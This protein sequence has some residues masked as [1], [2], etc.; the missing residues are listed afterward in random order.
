M[1]KL[2][3]INILADV[4][5]QHKNNITAAVGAAEARSDQITHV[6][7]QYYFMD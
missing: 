5:T 1:N 4:W 2:T 3:E 7:I 6:R